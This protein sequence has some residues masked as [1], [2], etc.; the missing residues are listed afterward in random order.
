MITKFFQITITTTSHVHTFERLKIIF[1][2]YQ[3]VLLL[4]IT[5]HNPLKYYILFGDVFDSRSLHV[6]RILV[7]C[8]RLRDFY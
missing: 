8:A 2:M 6:K 7:F 3:A 4:N 1:T 5:H